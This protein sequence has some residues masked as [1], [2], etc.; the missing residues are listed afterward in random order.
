[1]TMD[2]LPKATLDQVLEFL[3]PKPHPF[4]LIRVGGRSDG[5]YL[6]PSEVEALD[7]CF[8]PGVRNKKSFEDDLFY[9]HGLRSHMADFSS[10]PQNFDTPL[11]EPHQ[12]FR[13]L[14]IAA[15]TDQESITLDDW[16]QECE[17]NGDANLILQMDIE[18]GEYGVIPAV[19]QSALQRFSLVVLEL[20]GL[21]NIAIDGKLNS[22]FEPTFRR[23][24]RHF[25]VI[26]AHPNNCCGW[27]APAGSSRRRVP[28][29]LELTLVSKEWLF[30]LDKEGRLFRS[31]L[32]P[33]PQ[34]I[35][36]NVPMKKPMHLLWEGPTIF[37]RVVGWSVVAR[38]WATYLLV[39]RWRRHV[40]RR[41]IEQFRRVRA[42]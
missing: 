32:V 6:V 15:K 26:H 39:W 42:Q 16:I 37:S 9:M 19:S 8:S 17:P 41:L 5:A 38:D 27:S 4:T 13:K 14:W 11:I 7:A 28:S 3:E 22:R 30:K 33:H 2:S 21:R 12:T 10:E 40:P 1:M 36:A 24:I 34:D 18:G 31:P 23:L 29:T 35:F 25:V 20:H